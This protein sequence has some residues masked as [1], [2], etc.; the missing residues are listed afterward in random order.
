MSVLV[1]GGAGFIGSHTVLQLLEQGYE[2]IV[3]DNFSNSSTKA[4]ERVSEIAGRKPKIITGD[5]RNY[6]TLNDLFVK[7]FMATTQF[8][9]SAS[10][11]GFIA[12]VSLEDGLARTLRYEFIEDNSKNRTFD[13][14]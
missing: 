10:A 7:K 4:L 9:S 14:E 2:V 3:L 13:T 6:E 12:P 11:T 8:D 1:T 5:V